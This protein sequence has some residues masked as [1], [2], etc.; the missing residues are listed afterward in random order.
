MILLALHP[1]PM[2]PSLMKRQWVVKVVR[3]ARRCVCMFLPSEAGARGTGAS[4]GS[5]YI[6]SAFPT[7]DVSAFQNSA[8]REGDGP[9]VDVE[10]VDCHL[11]G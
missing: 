3:T 6:R 8:R 9:V 1:S 4:R 7:N 11:D 10:C 5:R 2:V